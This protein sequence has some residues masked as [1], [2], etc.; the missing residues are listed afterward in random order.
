M[1]E[2][3]PSPDPT[4]PPK[5]EPSPDPTAPPKPEPSPDPTPKP[6]PGPT[7]G[8]KPGPKP[9]AG[10]ASWYCLPGVSDCTIGFRSRGMFAAASRALQR[11][12]GPHWRGSLVRVT[13]AKGASVTVRLIDTCG[14]P[15]GR[16][17]DLY[18]AAFRK[19]AAL[20]SGIKSVRIEPAS[21]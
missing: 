9:L 15:D 13:T 2:P 3:L 17:I 20:S 18:S 7:P 11:R 6:T 1:P 8:P 16:I 14:C 19:I 5:P 10:T 12:I 4:A 21:R